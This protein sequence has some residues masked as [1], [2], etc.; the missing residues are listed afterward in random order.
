[1]HRDPTKRLI[2]T[3]LRLIEFSNAGSVVVELAVSQT[4]LAEMSNLSRGFV[5]ACLADLQAEGIVEKRYGR[6]AIPGRKRLKAMLKG[7]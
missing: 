7:N 4:D 3:I 5:S 2:A 6:I 1:M